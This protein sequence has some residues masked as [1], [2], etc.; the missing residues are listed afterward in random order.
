MIRLALPLLFAILSLLAVIKAP[1]NFFWR[2]Q[3]ALTEFPWISI[4]ATIVLLISCFWL[5][6]YRTAA[7]CI[8]GIALILFSLPVVHGYTRM[9]QMNDELNATLPSSSEE[10]KPGFS[11]FRMFTPVP[12]VADFHMEYKSVNNKGLALDFYPSA[13]ANAPCV[14]VIHGGSWSSGDN[15]QFVEWNWWMAVQGFNVA[16]IDYRLAPAFKSPAQVEDVRDAITFLKAQRD[17]NIDTNRF[18]LLGRSAG[19][20]IALCAAYQLNMP[21]ITGVI[22]IYAPADMVWG[23]RIKGNPLVLNTDSVFADYLGGPYD[24][25]ADKYLEASAVQHVKAGSPA[26]LIIHGDN[27]CMV[28]FIHSQHLDSALTANNVTHYF[29]NLPGATHACDYNFNGPSGQ[30]MQVAIK[31]FLQ[32]RGMMR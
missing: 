23:A 5:E 14:I 31:R 15:K 30:L 1:S 20:Q 22:S 7:F 27:D 6:K 16:A 19:G 21:E 29:L 26:T 12:E 9:I 32:T 2:V 3:V 13:K 25:F 28:S 17:L 18:V 10:T 24:Q 8:T 4:F 11:F